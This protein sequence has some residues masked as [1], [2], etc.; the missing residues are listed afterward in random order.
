MAMLKSL[1]AGEVWAIDDSVA[2]KLFLLVGKVSM[3][4]QTHQ[5]K[6]GFTLKNKLK[7]NLFL[8]NLLQKTILN[9]RNASR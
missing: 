4:L 6:S 9:Q 2:L 3:E 7:L 8:L 1:I 5:R